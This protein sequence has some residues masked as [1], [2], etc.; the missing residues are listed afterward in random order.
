MKAERGDLV[1]A[2]PT[3]DFAL[4]SRQRPGERAQDRQTMTFSTRTSVLA[5]FCA[6]AACAGPA[7][8]PPA[9]ANFSEDL[10]RLDIPGPPAPVAGICWAS[11]VTPA[12]IQTVTE[13][14]QVSP[15][16]RDTAGNVTTAAS[17]RIETRQKMVQDR[18][19]VWFKSP[20]AEDLTPEFVAT[21]QRALKARG[22]YLLPLTGAMD[23]ATGA[24]VRRFQAER[25]LDSPVLSL[26]A[27][28]ELGITPTA[29]DDL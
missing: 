1:R 9:R 21:L 28:R 10:I 14:V 16:I 4:W 26:A 7:V 17:F 3:G 27:T 5:L 20:C 15:E 6:L 24:A 8:E 13:Q 29:L 19:E 18:E 12:V 2:F 23:A 22:Y 25:G 11:D